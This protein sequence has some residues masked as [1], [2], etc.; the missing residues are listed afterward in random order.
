[1]NVLVNGC[2]HVE[3]TELH[4]DP[5]IRRSLSWPNFINSW[6]VINISQA[7]SSNDSIARRTIDELENNHYNMVY[8]QWS[9]FDRIELQI[10]CYQDHNCHNEWFCINAQNAQTKSAL[11]NNPDFMFEL[12]R[13]VYLKQFDCAWRQNYSLAQIV[14]L[15]AYLKHRNIDYLFGF[16]TDE[17]FKISNPRTSLLDKTNLVGKSWMTFCVQNKFNKV[18]DHYEQAAHLAYANY[19]NQTLKEIR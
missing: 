5:T 6:N 13:D 12:S 4:S 18:I 10:P 17:Y 19:I 16:S 8:V 14:V 3:G 7:G 1:M 11:N 2:S 15:Q 9:Y